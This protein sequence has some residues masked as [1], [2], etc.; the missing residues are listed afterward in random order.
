MMLRR[1]WAD[2]AHIGTLAR[3]LVLT[4]LAQ[5]ALGTT[6]VVM[7]GHLGALELAAGGLA[8]TLFNLLRTMGVGLVTP[9][10]NLIAAA[11]GQGVGAPGPIRDL[12][13]A[14]FA[15]ATLA[16]LFAWAVMALAGPLLRLLGQDAAVVEGCTRYLALAAPG[17][18][19]LLWFQSLRNVMVGL[20]RPGPLLAVTLASV[21]VNIG[22]NLVL[23]DGAWGLPAWG[24]AGVALSS[25]LV[26]TA[27][28]AA[29]CM[30]ARRDPTVGPLLCLR[31]WR[32]SRAALK[33][34]L[35]LG[36]PVAA[37]Y[38][39]EA[40]F[41]SVLSLLAGTLGA[42]ALAAHTVVNQ[43][44]YVVFM[45][46]V[47]ISHA[48]SISISPA[49]ARH[50]TATVRRLGWTG[51]ALG[52]L[53]MAGAAAVYL[54]A[55]R[56]VLSAFVRPGADTATLLVV[57]TPLLWLAALLQFFDASQNIA[58]GLLRGVGDTTSAF[59]RTL[60][61]YWGLGLGSAWLL[62]G[63]A[64]LGVAGLW[65][66]LLVGLAATAAQLLLRFHRLT[67]APGPRA[68]DSLGALKKESTA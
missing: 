4:Q 51:L 24:L 1:G 8:L 31:I 2:A 50:D 39:S 55:P 27:S 32:T 59:F 37:T 30:L 66:G 26:N 6:S 38:G 53:A 47:G 45:V 65:L 9:T 15:V 68:S 54:A 22:L 10:A 7:L 36:L 3:P 21:V 52:W 25:T 5:V 33:R 16:G 49:W 61:G 17:I 67:A 44:V 11:P 29:F 58:I 13:R 46:A 28:F 14:G 56:L 57:A 62:A 12:A 41:F 34:T 40:G 19:P 64:G 43:A 60:L 42:T 48:V 35:A 20:R 63:Q 18:L 23:V